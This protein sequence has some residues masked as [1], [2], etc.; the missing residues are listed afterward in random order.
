MHR[1]DNSPT[2]DYKYE[3]HHEY[4]S[5]MVF[6]CFDPQGYEDETIT[7]CYGGGGFFPKGGIAMME[8]ED[9]IEDDQQKVLG[10]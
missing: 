2:I 7:A 5:T 10:T 4:Q 6:C 3:Y 9:S 1:S 8:D